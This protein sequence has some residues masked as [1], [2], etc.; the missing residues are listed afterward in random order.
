M[1]QLPADEA[2]NP[3]FTEVN[4]DFEHRPIVTG[5][6]AIDFEQVQRKISF[7]IRVIARN[8]ST[9]STTPSIT[10]SYKH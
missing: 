5:S 1:S 3:E 6:E 8:S 4:E 7:I 10:H 9:F 2:Q